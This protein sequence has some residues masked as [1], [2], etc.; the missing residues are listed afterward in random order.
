MPLQTLKKAALSLIE[1]QFGTFI[2]EAT[3]NT[4]YLLNR[5]ETHGKKGKSTANTLEKA[6]PENP[7]Q[8]RD[9]KILRNWCEAMKDASKSCT[10]LR[11]RK[12]LILR[13]QTRQQ[14]FSILRHPIQTDPRLDDYTRSKKHNISLSIRGTNLMRQTNLQRN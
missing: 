2:K 11:T 4:S 7:E 5:L 1:R 12:I 9:A 6:E 3:K 13:G 14:R 10:A 8:I